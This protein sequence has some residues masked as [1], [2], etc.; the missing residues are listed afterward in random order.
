[1]GTHKRRQAILALLAETG[2]VQVDALAAALGASPNTIRNDLDALARAGLLQRV[3]GGAVPREATDAAGNGVAPAPGL[4][5]SGPDAY[6][7][8]LQAQ[9]AEKERIGVWA[10]QLVQDGDALVLDASSTVFR[11]AAHLRA[12]KHLTVVTNGLNVALLLAQTPSNKVI[13]AANEVRPGSHSVVGPLNPD[14][15]KHFYAS[16]CFVSCTGFSLEQGLTELNVDEAIPKQQMMALA[17]EVIALVDHTKL[18]IVSAYRF[19]DVTQIHQLVMDDGIAPDVLDALR[20]GAECALTVVGADGARTVEPRPKQKEARQYRIGFGNLTE[21]MVFAQQVRRSLERAVRDFAGIELLVRNNNLD[22][23]TSLANVDWFIANE[24]DLMIEYQADAQAGNVIMDRFNR[25]GIPVIAVDIPLPGATFFG[26]D[27]YRAGRMA[28]EALGRWIAEQWQGRLDL[29]LRLEAARVGPPGARI[30]GQQEGLEA[31]LGALAPE[32]VR[33]LDFPVLVDEA[34]RTM[35][36]L[37][38]ELATGARIAIVAIND[39]VALGALAAFEAAGRLAQ[40]VAVGQN[41]DRLGRAA[42]RRDGFPFLG[43]TAYGPERYGE[44]LLALAQRILQGEPTPPALFCRHV[45][46]TRETLDEHYPFDLQ[47]PPPGV[48]AALDSL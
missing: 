30:Q 28:G 47:E 41:G 42:L 21:K 31:L 36:A 14:L 3:R 7:A 22:P 18:G 17:R 16:K 2:D 8:R 15:L 23:A 24:I 12:R 10:A 5:L 33:A 46:L 6:A 4:G 45:F 20:A 9:Q 37:L 39:E 44:Q 29:L 25:A 1:M 13:L 35:A 26:A 38:P 34:Q 19:A 32:Q 11:M 43:S 40:V 48:T 27:N